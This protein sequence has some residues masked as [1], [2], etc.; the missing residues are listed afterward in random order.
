MRL[1][2]IQ[3]PLVRAC[4]TY[5]ERA[6]RRARYTIVQ[7][8]MGAY[9]GA[10]P[11]LPEVGAHGATEEACAAA[12]QLALRDWVSDRIQHGLDLPILESP[13]EP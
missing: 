13:G 8:R 10:I 4:N 9:Q 6:M 5:I 12:L 1:N 3:D 7:H 11:G 2:H